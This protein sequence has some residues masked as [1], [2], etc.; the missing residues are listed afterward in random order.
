M[1]IIL[2]KVNSKKSNNC[3]NVLATQLMGSKKLLPQNQ[4]FKQINEIDIYNSERENCNLIRLNCVINPICSNVIF[5]TFSEVIKNEGNPNTVKLLNY[6]LTD[7]YISRNDFND[8]IYCKNSDVFMYGGILEAIRDT[9]ISSNLCGFMYHCG[10]DIFNNHI[11]RNNTFKTVCYNSVKN[12][13]FNTLNDWMRDEN[14][15]NIKGIIN[16][17]QKLP[18]TSDKMI[19][20]G[21]IESQHLYTTDDV[22]TFNNSIENKLIEKNG[23]FG[24]TNIGKF[25][26]VD[27]NNETM[28]IFR[29][30]NYRR[31]CD[32]IQMYP[33]SE[34]WTFT[35]RYNSYINRLE[36]N[37]NYCLTYPSSSTTQNIT[38]IR[39]ETNSLKIMYIN[40]FNIKLKNG[41]SA[42]KI[43]SISK[44]GLKKGDFINL[45]QNDDVIIG[46]SEVVEIEDEY[47]FYIVSN[48]INLVKKWYELTKADT[49]TMGTDDFYAKINVPLD[50]LYIKYGNNGNTINLSGKTISITSESQINKENIELNIDENKDY[51]SETKWKTI[52]FHG[53]TYNVK[54]NN[55]SRAI[56][57][58]QLA[59]GETTVSID[60]INFNLNLIKTEEISDEKTIY[61]YEI[62]NPSVNMKM[63]YIIS[64]DRNKVYCGYGD[65]RVTYYLIDNKFVNI[66]DNAQDFSFKKL[67]D[68]EEVDYYVRIFSKIPNWKGCDVKIDQHQLY[69]TNKN[70]IA[71]YQTLENDFENHIS[72]LAFAKNIYGDDISQVVYTDDIDISYLKDNLGRP[73]TSIYFTILKNNKGYK[74]WYGKNGKKIEI[75]KYSNLNDEDYHIEYS[76]CFGMLNCAF[77][78]SKES[79]PSVE[80]NN[81]MQ[82]NNIDSSF[83]YQG[84]DVEDL[85]HSNLV[86]EDILPNVTSYIN[87][88]NKT[89]KRSYRS[90]FKEILND[91]IQ[92]GVFYDSL[93]D[94]K[95]LGDTHFYGDLCAYSKKRLVEEPIQQIEMRFNTAQREVSVLDTSY[96]YFKKLYYDEI[97]TDDKDDVG[98]KSEV[99]EILH[100]NQHKEGYCYYPHYEIKIKTLSKTISSIKSLI[101]TLTK[102]NAVSNEYERQMRYEFKTMNPHNVSKGET[103]YLKYDTFYLDTNKLYKT[104]YYI[105]YVSDIINDN[106]FEC[107]IY[108]ENNKRVN[109]LNVFDIHNYRLFKKDSTTPDYATFT[110]DGS[111]KFIWRNVI[112]NGFDNQS[113]IENYP[114]FNGSFHVNKHINLFVRRQDPNEY[115]DLLGQTDIPPTLNK[116]IEEDNYY[117]DS[118]ISC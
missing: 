20:N 36:K 59:S 80:H 37:W 69:G 115:A 98:F 22:D 89:K 65:D 79:L 111:C 97:I 4:I 95:Y 67:V 39:E 28:D 55:N 26:V 101:M 10:L 62:T 87:N 60:D 54:F 33:S 81:S 73:L 44:H 109:T 117:K 102:I 108:D 92:Y 11:L 24:F 35:P 85:Q 75:R 41:L 113:D 12:P 78:L 82:I 40:D 38:F 9:Q 84:L 63:Q 15:V 16:N 18:I 72:T 29:V 32:F 5:N 61:Y 77:R 86:Y 110:K 114:F 27:N 8:K 91:E 2:N 96:S 88:D 100:A 103:I 74:E 21:Y 43:Y 14:G 70:L 31:S 58:D 94:K 107:I 48:G 51:T 64:S 66:D 6:G 99:K 34:L 19:P 42:I 116:I 93:T 105:C 7:G 71:R 50:N 112:N 118:E 76:H 104:Y 30:I 106:I 25:S 13:E 53:I 90:N 52:N 17:K 49:D 68:N 57:L 1:E 56:N 23:W 45:Y 3:N 47:I 46:Y 83:Q